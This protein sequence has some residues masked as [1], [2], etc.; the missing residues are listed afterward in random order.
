MRILLIKP[1]QIGDSLILTPTITALKRAYPEAEIWVVVR[2]GCEGILAGCPSIARILMVATVEKRDRRSGDWWKELRTMWQIATHKFDFAFELGDGSRGRNLMR[3]VSC[4]RRFSVKP[5]DSRGR[6]G[7]ERAGCKISTF[8]WETCHRVEKDFYSV[9]EFL[10][11]AGPI[12]PLCFES[13][14]AQSWTKGETL[15]DFCVMQIGSRQGYNRWH[16]EGWKEVCGALLK[17]FSNVVVSCGPVAQESE[18]AAWLRQELGPRVI[19]T[20]GGTTWPEMAWLLGRAKLYVGPNTAAM[21]LAAACRCPVVALLGPSIEDYWHPW[22]APYRI[23]TSHGYVPAGDTAERYAQVK[24]REM[25]E[26]E[27]RDVMAA[28]DELLSEAGVG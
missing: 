5:A 12:P 13:R 16:R 1:K 28:C 10:P 22:Q 19:S 20:E 23:V 15:T 17:R 21:H 8:D 25:N 4:Q 14:F 3:L 11:L 7:A 27:A 6:H 9:S 2:R 24:K 18:E 26:I